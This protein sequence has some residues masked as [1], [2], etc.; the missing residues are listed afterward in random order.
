MRNAI[1]K[2]SPRLLMLPWQI[3]SLKLGGISLQSS[4]EIPQLLVKHPRL[5]Q[6]C[7]SK[8]SIERYL[9]L[10]VLVLI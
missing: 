10:Y 6:D 4:T 3:F 1:Y 9:E 7:K 8:I 2:V 5:H